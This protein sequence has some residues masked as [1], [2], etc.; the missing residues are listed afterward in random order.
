MLPD[1]LPSLRQKLLAKAEAEAQKEVSEVLEGKQDE[2]VKVKKSKK[3]KVG[4]A[5]LNK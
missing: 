3:L 4:K 2:L 1:K 5:K